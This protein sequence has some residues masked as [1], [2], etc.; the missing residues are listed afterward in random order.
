MSKAAMGQSQ[1][2]C[3][4][5]VSVPNAAGL[6]QVLPIAYCQLDIA[7]FHIANPCTVTP[8]GTSVT[9]R[10]LAH[11]VLIDVGKLA[12]ERGPEKRIWPTFRLAARVPHCSF[13]GG[14]CIQ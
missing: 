8:Y 11:S 7:G 12:L 6:A 14:T 3:P 13:Q 4:S 2:A 5:V 1:V 9:N 10:P